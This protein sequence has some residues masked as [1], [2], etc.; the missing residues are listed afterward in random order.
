MVVF[1][2]GARSNGKSVLR[3]V[4]VLQQLPLAL[5]K[6][7]PLRVHLI[8]FRYEFKN[9]SPS[10][11]AGGGWRHYFWM[12]FHLYHS[13]KVTVL[14]A[15]SL[16]LSD[17]AKPGSTPSTTLTNAQVERFRS[18]LAAMLRTKTI[19]MG[20]DDFVSFNAYWAHVTSGG[21]K[22]AAEFTDRKAPHEHA[23]WAKK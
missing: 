10:Q 19:D 23:Q 21:R 22:P 9:F 11:S 2:E 20:V 14:G 3:F 16:S 8:A 18:L 1:P 4:P 6:S 17:S 7:S 13:L 5:D 15:K 12:S